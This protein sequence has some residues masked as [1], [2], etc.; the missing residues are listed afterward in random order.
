MKIASLSELKKEIKHLETDELIDLVSRMAKFSKENKELLN[1]LLFESD[2]ES[3]YVDKIKEN[4]N[5]QFAELNVREIRYLKKGLQRMVREIKKRV[6]YS[7]NKQT[8]IEVWIHFCQQISVRNIR[9]S[10]YPVLINLYNRQL[11]TVEKAISSLD[12]DL[13]YDYREDFL[14]IE[15]FSS[16]F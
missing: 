11:K 9:I 12:E 4:I 13:Q 15:S 2:F 5:Q 3:N 1:Y 10:R 16:N 6:K 14:E 8:E 7:A